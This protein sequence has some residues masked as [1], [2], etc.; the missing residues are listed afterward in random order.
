MVFDDGDHHTI[1]RPLFGD[2][3]NDRT[4]VEKHT[5][6]YTSHYF[7]QHEQDIV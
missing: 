2:S 7:M 5:M 1:V 4:V 3:N 6:I